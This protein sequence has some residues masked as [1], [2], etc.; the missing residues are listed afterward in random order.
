M[1]KSRA[2]QSIGAVAC[3]ANM[4]I[5]CTTDPQ[6]TKLSWQRFEGTFL[7]FTNR[8]PANYIGAVITRKNLP[9]GTNG[10]SWNTVAQEKTN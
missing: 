1:G 10:T 8:H 5:A 9:H 3:P 7:T 4:V 6:Q 2:N